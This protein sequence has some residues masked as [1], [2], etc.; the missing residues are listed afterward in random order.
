LK[1]SDGGYQAP[2]EE[3]NDKVQQEEH[4]VDRYHQ[5]QLDH[6]E[7]EI[8]GLDKE[9]T[10]RKPFFRVVDSFQEL[11]YQFR[12]EDKVES[13]RPEEVVYVEQRRAHGEEFDS[14]ECDHYEERYE[15]R[16][17]LGEELA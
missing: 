13:R 1:R 15:C 11:R 5:R 2:K 8:E 6:S 9:I 14:R 12:L 17:E 10:A 4:C 7:S 3:A 16:E